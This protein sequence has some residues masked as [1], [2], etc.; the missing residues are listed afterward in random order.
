MFQSR[1]KLFLQQKL[2]LLTAALMCP[3]ALAPLPFLHSLVEF[4]FGSLLGTEDLHAPIFESLGPSVQLGNRKQRSS[5]GTSQPR[6]WH[7]QK[8]PDPAEQGSF[9]V[10]GQCFEIVPPRLQDDKRAPGTG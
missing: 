8:L 3:S 9:G 7:F 5:F 10:C 2:P 6:S 4:S 1:D